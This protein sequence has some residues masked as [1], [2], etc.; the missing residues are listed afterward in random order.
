MNLTVQPVTRLADF[1]LVRDSHGHAQGAR[2][3]RP[4]GYLRRYAA[5]S[6]MILFICSLLVFSLAEPSASPR[7]A[8]YLTSPK[9]DCRVST[10]EYRYRSSV[11]LK[12]LSLATTPWIT[13]QDIALFDPSTGTLTVLEGRDIPY[14]APSVHGTLFVVVIDGKRVL[15]GAFWTPYSSLCCCHLPIIETE[16]NFGDPVAPDG[17]ARHFKLPGDDPRL[18]TLFE[19]LGKLTH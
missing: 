17:F 5:V 10:T 15:A 2:P 18:R 7:F 14:P 8:I 12:D 11:S 1:L 19:Q 13:E 3:S 16:P 4:A 6:M 9:M